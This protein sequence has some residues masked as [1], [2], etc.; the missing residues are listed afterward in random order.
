MAFG[1]SLFLQP[2]QHAQLPKK[3]MQQHVLYRSIFSEPSFSSSPFS[4]LISYASTTPV[5]S[6]ACLPTSTMAAA[7]AVVLCLWLSLL[8]SATTSVVAAA[9]T[10]A[11]SIA[12]NSSLSTARSPSA[13]RSASGR[14]AFGFYPVPGGFL[15]GIWLETAPNRTIVWTAFRD[16]PP[17]TGG[18]LSLLGGRL[19]LT[20][21]GT[22][23]IKYI[24]DNGVSGSYASMLDTGDF[25]IYDGSDQI[26]WSTAASPTDTILARQTM[27]PGYQLISSSSAFNRSTGMFR[28]KMQQDGNL[29]LY[30]IDGDDTAIFAYWSSRTSGAQGLSLKL[31]SQGA[32]FLSADSGTYPRKNLTY[33]MRRA[34][35][36]EVLYRATVEEDGVFRLY[37][38]A[39]YLNGSSPTTSILWQ[40]PDSPCTVK[41]ICGLNSY[42]SLSADGQPQCLCPHGFRFN[43]PQQW[44]L[45]CKRN[46]SVGSCEDGA[47][48][49]APTASMTLLNAV[50]QTEDAY[51][52]PSSSS[53]QD[54]E[55]E[56]LADCLCGAALFQGGR[57]LKQALPFRFAQSDTGAQAFVKVGN[58]Q[59]IDRDKNTTAA[60]GTD[61]INGTAMVNPAGAKKTLISLAALLMISGACAVCSVFLASFLTALVYKR[62][63]GRYICKASLDGEA[64]LTSFSYVQLMT[65]TG[66]F[67]EVVGKG[68]FGTVFKGTLASPRGQK[69]VA[70]KR[71]DRMAEEGEREF[72][73]EVRAIGRI[74][75]RNLARLLGFC[76]EGAHRMLVYDYMSKGS[77][78]DVLFKAEVRPGWEER[79]RIALDVASGLRYLHDEC[80]ARIIHCDIKPQNILM[81]GD[82]TAKISDFGLAKLMLAEQTRTITQVRGTRGYLA[83]EWHKNA[84]ITTKTDVYSFG[85]VLLEIVCCRRSLELEAAAAEEMVLTEWAYGCLLSRELPRLVDGE[86]VELGELERMVKTG[87]WCVQSDPT[88]RPTM[89]NVVLMLEGNI[90][91]ALPPPPEPV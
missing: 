88:S 67:K 15:V 58:F 17:V 44:R 22:D 81:D 54:C 14:F 48:R 28:L 35:D 75:H 3:A 91:I 13:W 82:G 26:V 68:A 53:A 21:T 65:A 55:T 33:A 6:C 64:P 12:L 49:G 80:E 45:G 29:V 56:C 40:A 37:G 73:R 69:I 41:G 31:D 87:L 51:S 42:C 74:H 46:F 5:F 20:A 70:V 2:Y 85:V 66:G 27:R 50:W 60:A 52:T 59:I 63:F 30:P 38:H 71:L 79:V 47:V 89:R 7:A 10:K 43:N 9:T 25:V 86:V 24:S 34:P 84:P 83:P 18:A 39:F 19:Q 62:K 4:S 77:L 8:G 76:N 57:C 16:E 78:A 61:K 36:A 11:V 1:S 72:Q 90:N 32:L 23:G